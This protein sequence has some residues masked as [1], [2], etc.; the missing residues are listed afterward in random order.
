MEIRE[1]TD[2]TADEIDPAAY[3]NQTG[4]LDWHATILHRLEV[5]QDEWIDGHVDLKELDAVFLARIEK[6]IAI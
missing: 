5:D 4:V 6:S 3:E 2:D 1:G